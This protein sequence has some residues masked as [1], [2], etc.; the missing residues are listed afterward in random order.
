MN[1]ENLRA[2]LSMIKENLGEG[3]VDEPQRRAHAI[4]LEDAV[5]TGRRNLSLPQLLQQIAQRFYL[6]GLR[7]G[8]RLALIDEGQEVNG[9]FLSLIVSIDTC[10]NFP[11]SS[12]SLPPDSKLSRRLALLAIRRRT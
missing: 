5:T 12:P 11:A 8:V 4:D 2:A 7:D 6:E 1:K 9:A 10:T 3:D